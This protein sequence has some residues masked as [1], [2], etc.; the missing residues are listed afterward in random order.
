M[1]ASKNLAAVIGTGQTKYVAKRQDVSMN[2]LVREAIDRAM[3]DAG[4]DWDDID[5][6]VVGKAPDFFEGVMMP[7]LFMADAIGATGKPMIRVHTAGSV[8]GSTGVVAASLVQSGKYRRVLALAWEKQSESNAMWA[9]SIPVPFSVPVGA[10]AGGYFAPHVRAYIQRSKA[11]LDTGAMV[12]VKDRLNA[13]KNPLAHLHQ[14]DITVEK[15]MSSPMLWDPIRF[16]ETC[17]SS[18]GACAIVVGDE[19]TADRRIKEGHA[20]AWVHATALRTE[21]LDY[22]GRDRVNPQAGRDAAAALWKDAGITSPIDEIDVA[23]IYVPFSWFEPMWLENLGFAAEGEGWKL[24]QAGETAIGGKIPVN[25]SGGVLSSNPI[26]ASGLIRF[27]EA[28][29]QVMGKAGDHQVPGAKKALG[30]AYGGGSQYY[31]MWVVGSEKPAGKE[32]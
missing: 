13:A 18:D 31:S 29:I 4:V 30:H 20:V 21:P 27:A 5:A 23:E 12:A 9:L 32:Q 11:P 7:E 14:P 25:A 2:G 24:T 15:V 28:A 22:T 26:G 19:D 10:G 16:D 8:G 6:V 17:P 1:G 3:T